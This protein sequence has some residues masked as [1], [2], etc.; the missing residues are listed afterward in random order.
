MFHDMFVHEVFGICICTL[1]GLLKVCSPTA[2]RAE[3]DPLQAR[4]GAVVATLGVGSV[5]KLDGQSCRGN[6]I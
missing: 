6:C 5:S 4:I 1:K 2:R 3:D